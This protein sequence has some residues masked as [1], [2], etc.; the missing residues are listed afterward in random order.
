M[1]SELSTAA[2]ASPES[3]GEAKLQRNN[4]SALL[5]SREC[6]LGWMMRDTLLC[7]LGYTRLTAVTSQ[8]SVRRFV[9]C[10]IPHRRGNGQVERFLIAMMKIVETMTSTTATTSE[11]SLVMK[12]SDI[13]QRGA[14]SWEFVTSEDVSSIT[15]QLYGQIKGRTGCLKWRKRGNWKD[16]N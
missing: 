13:S 10:V 3:K 4:S 16:G 12:L 1:C 15:V 2:A 5:F 11:S 7:S 9:E 14:Q 8:L 6:M